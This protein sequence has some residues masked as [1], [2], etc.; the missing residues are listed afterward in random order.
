MLL[1]SLIYSTKEG[2][3]R[4][5]MSGCGAVKSGGGVGGRRKKW[6]WYESK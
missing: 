4:R 2:R 6:I 3:R 1:H 5:K